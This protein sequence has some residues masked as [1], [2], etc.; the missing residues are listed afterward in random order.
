MCKKEIQQSPFRTI[1]KFHPFVALKCAL[2]KRINQHLKLSGGTSQH[3]YG[4]QS[5]RSLDQTYIKPS[6]LHV[7]SLLHENLEETLYGQRLWLR[8]RNLFGIGLEKV[9]VRISLCSSKVC[10]V[11]GI[12]FVRCRFPQNISRFRAR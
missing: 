4:E 7:F 8:R 3:L 11:F 12:H 9:R 5:V 2:K 1:D 6:L 10:I